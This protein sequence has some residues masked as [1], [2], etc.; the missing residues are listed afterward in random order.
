[1]NKCCVMKRF[2]MP[3]DS[4][5]VGNLLLVLG[6]LLWLRRG[7]LECV[8]LVTFSLTDLFPWAVGFKVTESLGELQWFRDDSLLLLVITNFRVTRQREILSQGVTFESVIGQNTTQVR[9][10]DEEDTVHVPDFAFV[11]IGRTEDTG[12]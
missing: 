4:S 3:L 7:K 6:V 2:S 9:M 1:M 5:R 12:C 10:A 11:P 8:R